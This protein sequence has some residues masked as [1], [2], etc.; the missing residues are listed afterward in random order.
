MGRTH[1]VALAGIAGAG[2]WFADEANAALITT[3]LTADNYYAVYATVDGRLTLVGR[4]EST[5]WGSG[6]YNWSQPETFTF[7]SEGPVY[8]AVWSDNGTTQ[9]FLGDAWIDGVQHSTGSPLWRVIPT[10]LDL[11]DFSPTPDAAQVAAF[12]GAAD[13]GGAWEAPYVGGANGI[14]P[15]GVIPG[16][17]SG[18]RW[19][20]WDRP[21]ADNPLDCETGV[22]EYLIFRLGTGVIP[23]PGSAMVM[24]CAGLVGLRR[25]R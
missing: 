6:G 12:A 4:N 9:G 16:V 7:S 17:S 23:T 3:T 2:L 13:A 22:G 21:G 1:L 11:G 15:W 10:H 18:A 5:P 8:V 20:W 24:A 14:A 19:T 25:R